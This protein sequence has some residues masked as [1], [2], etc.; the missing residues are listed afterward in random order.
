MT[1][2]ER[3]KTIRKQ[4]GL[5]QEQ[6]ADR[7]GVSRQAVTKWETDAGLPDID[8]I[9]AIS[10]IFDVS[11]DDLLSNKREMK[12]SDK[13]LFESFTEY[14]IDNTKHYDIKLGGAKNVVL[15]GYEGEKLHVKLLSNTISSLKNDFKVKIDDTKKRIDVDV[16]RK[17]S[18]SEAEA[19]ENVD[20]FVELPAA[21]I[22]KVECEVI[23]RS[24]EVRSLECE[25]I[26]LDIKSSR[27]VLENVTGCVEIDCNL[28]ME[29]YCNSLNGEIDINQV[30][31]TSKIHIPEGTGFKAVKKGLGT[32]IS[33]EEE[34]KKT[35][36]FAS[37][38]A[39]NII[40]LNG[41]RSEL[42]ICMDK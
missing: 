2:S 38:D 31:A 22:G 4:A 34:G 18:I 13:Y 17:N 35:E 16:I 14:D 9:M 20:I 27:V 41:I 15:S 23:S 3:L 36:S 5:S 1:F 39:E 24:V 10:E 25:S 21:Y 12:K 30:S 29:V 7:L 40:E 33:Y 28:D 37:T 26:E 11:I 8:N 19:K 6:L 32:S 42:I